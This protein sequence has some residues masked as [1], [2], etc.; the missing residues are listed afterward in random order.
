LPGSPLSDVSGRE[1]EEAL[2][3]NAV[4]MPK[5]LGILIKLIKNKLDHYRSVP[6]DC[7]G[8]S[9]DFRPV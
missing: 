2:Q 3:T 1:R 6:E 5:R 9:G 7:N 4:F 8:R